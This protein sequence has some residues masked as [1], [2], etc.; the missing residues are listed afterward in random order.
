MEVA[1]FHFFHLCRETCNGKTTAEEKG[2]DPR[3]RQKTQ[4][5]EDRIPQSIL[6]KD[7]TAREAGQG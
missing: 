1:L 4:T 7:R 5:L 6:E 2:M 3:R